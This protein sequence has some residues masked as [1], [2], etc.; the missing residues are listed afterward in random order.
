MHG[1]L[2]PGNALE[3]VPRINYSSGSTSW[4]SDLNPSGKK[5]SN[6]T[7]P[8]CISEK[9]AEPDTLFPP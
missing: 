1:E 4:E 6:R 8:R 5:T 2:I 9:L 7:R 3:D